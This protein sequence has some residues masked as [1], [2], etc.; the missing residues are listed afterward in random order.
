LL[1]LLLLLLLWGIAGV[2]LSLQ[3]ENSHMCTSQ[4]SQRY[5]RQTKQ[6]K[7]TTEN[8]S[9]AARKAARSKQANHQRPCC[10]CAAVG[11]FWGLFES[12]K[13]EQPQVQVSNHNHT[14]EKHIK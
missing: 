12:V 3:E 5:A 9:L 14:L 11:H 7:Q 6:N 13:W 4:E 2:S 8:Y 1:L 10:C